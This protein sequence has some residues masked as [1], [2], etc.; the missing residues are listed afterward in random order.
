MA[1]L[2]GGAYPPIFER[3]EGAIFRVSPSGGAAEKVADD[4][5]FGKIASDGTYLY[6]HRGLR[7]LLDDPG[8]KSSSDGAP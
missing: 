8:P 7:G 4:Y 1:L 2:G 6:R 5:C 3:G